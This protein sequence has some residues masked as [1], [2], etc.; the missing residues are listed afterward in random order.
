M[1]ELYRIGEFANLSGVSAKTLRYYDDIG[2]LRPASVNSRT[3]RS[4]RLDSR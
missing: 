4:K 1:A 3:G 2:L